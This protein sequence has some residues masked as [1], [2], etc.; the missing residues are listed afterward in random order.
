MTFRHD[1]RARAN[2]RRAYQA[3]EPL[4]LVAYFGPQVGEVAKAEGLGFYASYVGFRGAPLGPASPAV[5]TSSFYNWNPA[6]VEKG[7]QDAL[8]SHSVEQLLDAREQIADKALTVAFGNRRGH[9][10]L[11]RLVD[12]MTELL[13][14][15]D[16]AGRPLG[17]A[18]LGLSRDLEPHVGLWQAFTTWREWR[19]DGHIAALVVN[20]LS[21]IEALVLH[22]S[23]HPDPA[24]KVSGMGRAQ[25]QKSRAWSD[26]QWGAA[27]DALRTRGLLEAGA[28]RLTE[29]GAALQRKVED[30]TDDAAAG[31]WAGVDDA[32]EI[33]A[34]ARPYVKAV[35][36]AG[37]LPGTKPKG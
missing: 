27:A 4:H 19:G 24:A 3:F 10:A 15:G 7:W 31:V 34:A 13:A 26:E 1:E 21:P 36:D 6:A 25:T 14:R 30:E 37:L 23:E 18:N 33:F 8:S 32:D 11:P 5:I 35:I 12:R 20:G 28:E 17:S 22:E 29:A 16:R 9:D 2:A